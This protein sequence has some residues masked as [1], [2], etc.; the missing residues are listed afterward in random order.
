GLVVVGLLIGLLTYAYG[1]QQS[2]VV[3]PFLHHP[4]LPIVRAPRDGQLPSCEVLVILPHDIQGVEAV[5]EATARI[6]SDRSVVF[7]Y[8]GDRPTSGH[9]EPFQ[10]DDPDRK[11]P[12]AH[13]VFAPPH[14]PARPP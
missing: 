5:L 8:R 11:D 4:E 2:P 6:A 13:A 10:G 7:L 12:A 3:F 14:R 1:R 9:P